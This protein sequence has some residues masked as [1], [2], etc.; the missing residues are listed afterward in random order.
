MATKEEIDSVLSTVQANNARLARCLGHHFFSGADTGGWAICRHCG[1]I[2]DANSRNWYDL[3][4]LHGR[5]AVTG[6]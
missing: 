1:G 2:I 4:H 6:C 3:G 5:R